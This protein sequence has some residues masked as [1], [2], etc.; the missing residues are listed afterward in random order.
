MKVVILAGGYGTRISEE[1]DLRPKPMIEI[2]GKPILWHIMK[3]YSAQGFNEFIIL[4]GYKSFVIKEFFANYFLH[5]SDVQI[6]VSKNHMEVLNNHSEDWTVTLLE[7]GLD[8]MTGGRIL[9]AK[10]H[11]EGQDFL[12]TYGDGVSNVNMIELIDFHRK[13]GKILTMTGIQPEGRFGAIDLNSDG[14]VNQF[15]EKPKGD[16]SYIN[17]GFFVCKPEIFNYIQG[18]NTVFEKTPMEQLCTNKQVMVYRHHGYWQ[19]MDTMRDKV[20]LNELWKTD[21]APWK[22]WNI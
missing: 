9:K 10:P 4:C 17:G 5:Q 8:T 7:T 1:S 2:G 21:R 6:K 13:H 15:I 3:G 16:G 19:C 14:S 18:D 22:V 20:R 12:L 11:L